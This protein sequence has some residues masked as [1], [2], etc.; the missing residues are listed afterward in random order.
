MEGSIT[1]TAP[2]Q[3]STTA[4]KA[5][6]GTSMKSRQRLLLL[7]SPIGLLLLWEAFVQLGFADRRFLPPPSA[8]AV[9]FW[10]LLQTGELAAHVGM[11]LYRISIGYAIG[12]APA[13]AIG[14]LMAMSRTVRY[15]VDPLVAALFPIPKIAIMPLLLLA[16]G[17]GEASKIALVAIATFFPVIINTY[18][19]ASNIEKIYIDAARNFGATQSIMF[20]RIVFFGALPM[21][22]AGLRLALGISFIVIV[23]AEFVA[24]K[25]GIGNLI[26]ASWEL[27]QVDRMFVGI[28]V[29]GILGVI[30]TWLLQEI[31]RM[32]I[33][34]KAD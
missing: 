33:P 17:F 19:G 8:I 20:R 18:A 31:E 22:F 4:T 16:L 32:V 14:L 29:I 27:M 15:L 30:S 25:T 3:P 12:V 2:P 26:W 21:I 9:R 24:A 13:I 28:V 6:G 1:K 5:R 23:A 10:I 11:S 34:W 7:V